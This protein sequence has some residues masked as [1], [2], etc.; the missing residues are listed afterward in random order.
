MPVHDHTQH[1]QSAQPQGSFWTS[2]A[3]LV[4]AAFLVNDVAAFS[5]N[6]ARYAGAQHEKGIRRVDD[7]LDIRLFGNVALSYF[8]FHNLPLFPLK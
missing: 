3:F 7:G 4:C 8:Y 6:R 5:M 2:R 1:H